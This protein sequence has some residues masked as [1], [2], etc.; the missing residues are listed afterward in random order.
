MGYSVY[1][2]LAE[3]SKCLICVSTRFSSWYNNFLHD[4]Y[5]KRGSLYARHTHTLDII[6]CMIAAMFKSPVHVL[7]LIFFWIL[8]LLPWLFKWTNQNLP[9]CSKFGYVINLLFYYIMSKATII[10]PACT[11][12]VKL[13]YEIKV[14]IL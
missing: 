2:Y 6:S 11:V 5:K 7:P 4:C 10:Y 13:K 9:P 1:A 8:Q 3:R 12:Q 14:Y